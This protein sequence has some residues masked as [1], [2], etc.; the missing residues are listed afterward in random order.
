[1]EFGNSLKKQYAVTNY[2]LHKTTYTSSVKINAILAFQLTYISMHFTL[3][4]SNGNKRA[5]ILIKNKSQTNN[6]IKIF[7]T[8]RI[9]S[10]V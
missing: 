2:L 5:Y 4:E 3:H 6:F 10:L 7:Q 1:M 9:S 8:I